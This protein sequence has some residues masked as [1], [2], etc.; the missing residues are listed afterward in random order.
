MTHKEIAEKY[1]KNE[2]EHVAKKSKEYVLHGRKV[3]SVPMMLLSVE[4]FLF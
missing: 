1:S 2:R 3:P 4:M